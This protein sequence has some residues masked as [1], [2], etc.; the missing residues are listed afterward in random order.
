MVTHVDIPCPNCP[1]TLKVRSTYLDR[2]IVCNHCEHRFQARRADARPAATAPA[3][4]PGRAE[5]EALRGE[6]AASRAEA[7]RLL[8]Q[9]GALQARADEADRLAD[10][11]RSARAEI[12]RLSFTV[13][14]VESELAARTADVERLIPAVEEVVAI[15]AERDRIADERDAASQAVA[16]L[17]ASL[18]D[19]E[20]RAREAGARHEALLADHRS[21][22]E[23]VRAYEAAERQEIETRTAAEREAL[24]REAAAT[25]DRERAER[26]AE[27]KTLHDEIEA[28]RLRSEQERGVLLPE[29]DRLRAELETAQAEAR[30]TEQ[31]RDALR[32]RAHDLTAGLEALQ[33]R[34]EVTDRL[35]E[36]LSHE[37]DQLAGRLADRE[38]ALRQAEARHRLEADALASETE[39]IR[40]ELDH[41]ARRGV[42]LAAELDQQ[43]ASIEAERSG[44]REALEALRRELDAAVARER[45]AVL[46]IHPSAASRDDADERALAE[47][48]SEA[49]APDDLDV[50][51]AVSREMDGADPIV[52]ATA[53][54]LGPAADRSG[55]AGQ[56]TARPR[57]EVPATV[58]PARR[59]PDVGD[60]LEE[61]FQDLRNHLRE[62]HD[63]QARDR[64]LFSRLSRLWRQDAPTS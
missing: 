4:V 36:S 16:R 50:I 42:E 8:A 17:K 11:L 5:D 52:P 2:W 33:G 32:A 34:G 38:E 7:D 6:L 37:R 64:R 58:G 30:R 26:D 63:A 45:A 47:A 23:A 41:L 31:E 28:I 61:R 39:A 59:G 27:R 24:V 48:A 44:H 20:R 53:A 49:P 14:M 56:E 13:Q 9:V 15:R 19:Q 21:E 60:S 29:L 12:D 51:P 62:M 3:T 18:V 55:S 43:H 35:A 1:K 10:E 40:A 57:E 46:A 54:D 22:I 25:L